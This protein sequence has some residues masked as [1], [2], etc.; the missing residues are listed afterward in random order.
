MSWLTSLASDFT[1]KI[2]S[3]VEEHLPTDQKE[4]VAE[5][6]EQS[7]TIS[8]L[9]D[10][11][12]GAASFNPTNLLQSINVSAV[13]NFKPSA[14][15]ETI[16]TFAASV[17]AP[18]ASEHQNLTSEHLSSIRKEHA[19]DRFLPWET[20]EEEKEILSPEVREVI[21]KFGQSKAVFEGPFLLKSGIKCTSVKGKEDDKDKEEEVVFRKEED[22]A[23]DEVG[24]I[25]KDTDEDTEKKEEKEEDPDFPFDLDSHLGLIRRIMEV[26]DQLVEAQKKWCSGGGERE[27]VFWR[28]YFYHCACAREAAGLSTAEIWGDS[29]GNLGREGDKSVH[30]DD[31]GAPVI[32]TSKQ[33]EKGGNIEA[34]TKKELSPSQTTSEDYEIVNREEKEGGLMDEQHGDNNEHVAEPDA[35]VLEKGIED[36]D[37]EIERELANM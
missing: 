20:E 8:S 14:L 25:L 27:V 11:G 18:L 35:G 1:D 34:L 28:N 22:D 5:D 16:D 26:D 6:S 23:L 3:V 13:S 24:A 21:L 29:F 37:A 31:N 12:Q 10:D 4:D 32:N 36:L 19:F 7:K 33:R 2:S 9:F 17:A 30:R 15:L